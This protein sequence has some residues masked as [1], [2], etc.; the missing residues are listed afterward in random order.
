MCIFYL[1]RNSS[2]SGYWYVTAELNGRAFADTELLVGNDPPCTETNI[3]FF[4]VHWFS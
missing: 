4:L 3:Y 2:I 1:N